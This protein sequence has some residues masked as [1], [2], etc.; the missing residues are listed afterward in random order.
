MLWF[1]SVNVQ[2]CHGNALSQTVTC[3]THCSRLNT[4]STAVFHQRIL[5]MIEEPALW[6]ERVNSIKLPMETSCWQP[7]CL[8]PCQPTSC[9]WWASCPASH[10]VDEWVAG[11]SPC[12]FRKKNVFQGKNSTFLNFSA[13]FKI[14][15]QTSMSNFQLSRNCRGTTT[16]VWS[17]LLLRALVTQ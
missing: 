17:Q 16:P 13:I 12:N 9:R 6:W 2:Q 1:C 10:L 7:T 5:L 14:P 8:V 3:M 4:S 15:D 11:S